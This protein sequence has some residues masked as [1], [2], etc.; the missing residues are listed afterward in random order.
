MPTLGEAAGDS[1]RV[2]HEFQR[3]IIAG[4]HMLIE[5]LKDQLASAQR[6]ATLGRHR[7]ETWAERYWKVIENLDAYR[8]RSEAVAVG[9]TPESNPVTP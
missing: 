5:Q 8:T 7:A 4:Q 3:G 2:D 1:L 6:D 9:V